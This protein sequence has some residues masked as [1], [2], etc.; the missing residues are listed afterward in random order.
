MNEIGLGTF[1]VAA[2]LCFFGCWPCSPI[3]FCIDDLKDAQHRCP[4]CRQVCPAM[5][6]WPDPLQLSHSLTLGLSPNLAVAR[7]QEDP[8]L[9]ISSRSGWIR[10]CPTVQLWVPA[11]QGAE[12]TY[13][14]QTRCVVTADPTRD[15][16]RELKYSGTVHAAGKLWAVACR[17]LE[18]YAGGAV[19]VH[20]AARR[21]QR[22]TAGALWSEVRACCCADAPTPRPLLVRCSSRGL[23]PS[24]SLLCVPRFP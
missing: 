16:L 14:L 10:A 24:P 11:R 7:N 8:R 20:S 22:S 12:T 19:G 17:D 5:L 15:G 9:L 3:P 2:G 1:G 21:V 18:R 23:S 4:N 6:T 13:A